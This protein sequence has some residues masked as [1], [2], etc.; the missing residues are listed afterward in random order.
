MLVTLFGLGHDRCL[1][2]FCVGHGFT[3]WEV[4][5]CDF[6]HPQFWSYT[7]KRTEQLKLC[8]TSPQNR[9]YFLQDCTLKTTAT[10]LSLFC[11]HSHLLQMGS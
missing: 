5:L 10:G 4:H 11:Y 7:P 3:W 1:G 8:T 9:N 2:L 6:G